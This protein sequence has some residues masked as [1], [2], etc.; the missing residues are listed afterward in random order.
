MLVIGLYVVAVL[1]LIGIGMGLMYEILKNNPKYLVQS[2]QQDKADIEAKLS[3][4][5]TQITTGIVKVAE[6]VKAAEPVVTADAKALGEKII[7]AVQNEVSK[8]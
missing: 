7:T 8:L 6:E 5:G 3:K 1:V 4:V 2:L